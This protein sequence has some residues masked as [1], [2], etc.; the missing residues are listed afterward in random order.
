[1]V[2]LWFHC[3][4]K[5]CIGASFDDSILLDGV[6]K[7][8]VPVK[9][10]TWFCIALLLIFFVVCIMIFIISQWWGQLMIVIFWFVSMKLNFLFWCC[11]WHCCFQL[12]W[13]RCHVINKVID[14]PLVDAMASIAD[15]SVQFLFQI[16]F[17]DVEIPV[18]VNLIPSTLLLVS[19]SYICFYLVNCV[20]YCFHCCAK[21]L[22]FTRTW[23]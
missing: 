12:R 22:Y 16:N 14:I 2:M 8:N 23:S 4:Y 21:Y 10:P 13:C 18:V 3:C 17:D 1:M 15:D 20:F 5:I 11:R 9:K 19:L 6:K 7:G